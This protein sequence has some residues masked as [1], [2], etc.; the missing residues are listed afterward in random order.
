[1]YLLVGLYDKLSIMQLAIRQT[2]VDASVGA[3]ITTQT[4]ESLHHATSQVRTINNSLM[5]ACDMALL[6]ATA[7][8]MLDRATHT[9]SHEEEPEYTSHPDS[10]PIMP[11]DMVSIHSFLQNIQQERV[12]SPLPLVGISTA[13]PKRLAAHPID[14]CK[15]KSM[16]VSSSS[17]ALPSPNGEPNPTSRRTGPFRQTRPPTKGVPCKVKDSHRC[18]QHNRG[19]L[20]DAGPIGRPSMRP[21]NQ[22]FPPPMMPMTTLTATKPV[23]GSC[24]PHKVF[25]LWTLPWLPMFT[26]PLKRSCPHLTGTSVSSAEDSTPITR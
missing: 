2:V 22:Y 21:G 14:A 6:L 16:L 7:A 17:N 23:S 4:M 19:S 8:S 1:M 26:D 13:P 12:L 15:R 24:A 3:R 25:A 5:V 11:A 20:S 9:I 18:P 10:L